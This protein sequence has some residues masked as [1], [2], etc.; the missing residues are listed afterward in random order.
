MTQLYRRISCYVVI[1][2]DLVEVFEDGVNLQTGRP[3]GFSRVFKNEV[4]S[5]VRKK[6]KKT[7]FG[8]AFG[9]FL[10]DAMPDILDE[11]YKTRPGG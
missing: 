6:E 11:K 7:D 10:E 5:L 9:D 1:T 2:K 8:K 3:Q 4:P